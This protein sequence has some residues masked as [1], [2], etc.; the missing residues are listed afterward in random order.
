MSWQ[1]LDFYGGLGLTPDQLPTYEEWQEEMRLQR[2]R[3][4]GVQNV[5]HDE[6]VQR[7]DGRLCTSGFRSGRRRRRKLSGRIG[8]AGQL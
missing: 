2:E 4:K 1:R 5:D 6:S 3:M 7:H 8:S